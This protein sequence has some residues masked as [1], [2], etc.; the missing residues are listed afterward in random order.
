MGTIYG[1]KSIVTDGLILHHDYA[2]IKCYPGS[3]TNVTDLTNNKY[4]AA[5]LVGNVSLLSTNSGCMDFTGTNDLVQL[6]EN[7]FNTELNGSNNWTMSQWLNLD[8]FAPSTSS[9]NAPIMFNFYGSRNRLFWTMGDSGAVD[10]IHMRGQIA[11]T[12]QSPVSSETLALNTWY[13]IC[14]TY[15]ASTGF[16]AYT[17]GVLGDTSSVVGAPSDPGAGAV[18]ENRIGCGFSTRRFDGQI[19]VA[20]LYNT[21]L[22]AA[23]VLQNF[24]AL[25]K[26]F[27]V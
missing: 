17:N 21:D 15:N 8:A 20:S 25:R 24:E 6:H 13:H 5:T 7:D 14:F 12:W 16:K 22:S 18:D 1:D 3:G 26:R 23:E 27:G 4:P 11:G 19:A 10:K 2:N 9:T